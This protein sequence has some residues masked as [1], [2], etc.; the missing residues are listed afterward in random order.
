[1]L[2]LSMI[3]IR[4]KLLIS[5]MLIT[6]SENIYVGKMYHISATGL[7]LIQVNTDDSQKPLLK[8]KTLLN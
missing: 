4:I 1:M 2:L 5:Q 6:I 8:K 7:L 3:N